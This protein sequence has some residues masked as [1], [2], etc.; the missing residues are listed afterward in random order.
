MGRKQAAVLAYASCTSPPIPP[1]T[2]RPSPPYLCAQVVVRSGIPLTVR[3]PD[4]EELDYVP[5]AI[6]DGSVP[7]VAVGYV[8]AD[9][10]GTAYVDRKLP[11][12]LPSALKAMSSVWHPH[13]SPLPSLLVLGTLVAGVAAVVLKMPS[14]S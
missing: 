1:P 5:S 10:D 13:L 2:P 4:Y 6:R 11:A 14:M 7:V 3:P 9:G 12:A 8:G